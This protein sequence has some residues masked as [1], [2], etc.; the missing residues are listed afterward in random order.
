MLST[1]EKLQ[2]RVKSELEGLEGDAKINKIVELAKEAGFEF[3]AEDF[4][5]AKKTELSEEDLDNVNG[6]AWWEYLIPGYN[7]YAAGR[8]IYK[9]IKGDDK[10]AQPAQPNPAPNPTDGGSGTNY[11]NSND[12]GK[13]MANQGTNNNNNNTGTMNW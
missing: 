11:T 7:I 10:P 2:A 5:A 6:G 1:D 4:K 9:A 8:D 13:Q 12:G 3:T